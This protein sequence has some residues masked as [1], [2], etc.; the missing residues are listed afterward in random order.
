MQRAHEVPNVV[1]CCTGDDTLLQLLPHLLEQLELC[2]KSLTGYLEKKRLVFPRFFF[3]S[4]PALLEILGQASDSHTIQA[5]LLSVF[6][7]TKTVTFDEKFYDKIVAVNSQEGES[8]SLD[9]SV[10]AQGNVEVWLG[11]L[12]KS[13]RNS[14]HSIIK[15]AWFAINDIANFKLMDFETGHPAQVGLLGIQMLWTR[16]A[17]EALTQAKVD[18]KIMQ[19]TAQFFSDILNELIGVTTQELSK[20]DRTKFETLITIHVHQKDIFDDLVSWRSLS[21]EFNL[22]WFL[23]L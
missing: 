21:D 4:D 19:Q 10:M 9:H 17:Q 15:A 2:Q 22:Y 16:D 23:H 18:R 1:T 13:S 6:D 14:L 3:V 11:E 7:N 8:I 12:L 20:I 5:H